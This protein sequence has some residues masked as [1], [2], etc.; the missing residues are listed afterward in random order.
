MGG[1]ICGSIIYYIFALL[2]KLIYLKIKEIMKKIYLTFLAFLAM[3]PT[4]Q[5][6]TSNLE[7]EDEEIVVHTFKMQIHNRSNDDVSKLEL[8]EIET[9]EMPFEGVSDCSMVVDFNNGNRFV[10]ALSDMPVVA[11]EPKKN[12]MVISYKSQA[13]MLTNLY[14]VDV[15]NVA[16][17][18]FVNSATSVSGIAPESNEYRI[19]YIDNDRILVTGVS[20]SVALQVYDVAGALSCPHINRTDNSAEIS[21]YALPKGAYIISIGGLHSVKVFK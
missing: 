9:I 17:C 2:Q 10:C 12:M 5:A 13:D 16:K 21:L 18:Y 19:S 15:S 4:V 1:V 11:F 3:L 6:Q 14:V 20:P 7:L 8:S